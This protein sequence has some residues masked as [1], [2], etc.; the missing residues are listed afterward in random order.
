MF[1]VAHVFIRVP[2][3]L[4]L[5]ESREGILSA[6]REVVEELRWTRND[7]L[8][9]ATRQ[10]GRLTGLLFEEDVAADRLLVG[11]TGLHVVVCFCV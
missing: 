5:L 6:I 8:R 2:T 4:D 7:L 1:R 10:L 11:G 3:G 9:G